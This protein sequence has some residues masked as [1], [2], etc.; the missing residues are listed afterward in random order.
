MSAC[1]RTSSGCCDLPGWT[2]RS[3]R[4]VGHAN[5]MYLLS[6]D[7]VERAKGSTFF[8]PGGDTKSQLRHTFYYVRLCMT[9]ERSTPERWV[10]QRYEKGDAFDLLPGECVRVRSLEKFGLTERVLG[11][12]GSMSDLARLG[13]ALLH[14]PFIDPLYPSAKDPGDE[15]DPDVTAPLLLALVNHSKA[16]VPLICGQTVIAKLCLFDVSDTYPVTVE[17]GSATARKYEDRR[18]V[19]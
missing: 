17:K 6:R 18:A 11:M 14:G 3:V 15:G 2:R 4:A 5:P 16:K 7:Q 10:E 13:V 19:D 1:L 9:V 12:F 8:M